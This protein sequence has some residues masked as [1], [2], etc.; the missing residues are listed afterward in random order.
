MTIRPPNNLSITQKLDTS[1]L[2]TPTPHLPNMANIHIGNA[3]IS[4][5]P[6]APMNCHRVAAGSGCPANDAYTSR[7]TTIN[8][9]KCTRSKIQARKPYEMS[10]DLQQTDLIQGTTLFRKWLYE[11]CRKKPC[12]YGRVPIEH[13]ARHNLTN[14]IWPHG[15]AHNVAW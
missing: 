10:A 5:A 3:S 12:A 11:C 15:I 7:S 1:F 6:H 4:R 8:A 14:V 13:V 2:S 9:R